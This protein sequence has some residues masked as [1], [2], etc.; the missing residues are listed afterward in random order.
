MNL[1]VFNMSNLQ[2]WEQGIVNRNYFVVRELLRRNEFDQIFLVDFLAVQ[3]KKKP[4]GMRRSFR[5]AKRL[6]GGHTQRRGLF[7]TMTQR[8]GQPFGEQT[9]RFHVYQ[10]LGMLTDHKRDLQAISEWLLSHG[11][12]AANLVIWSYN[13]FLPEALTMPARLRVFDAVDN[14][15]LHASYQNDASLLRR[16]YQLISGRADVIF[17]VSEG[18]Q[19]LFPKEKA[20]WIPNGVDLSPFTKAQQVPADIS[21]LPKPVVGYVGTVQERL[22]F[23]LMEFVCKRHSD[24]SFVFIGPVWKGVKEQQV[25]LQTKCPNVHFLGRRPYA[26]VPAY[27]Q[28]MD[29][30]II[31][32]RLDAFISSTNPMKMYD[33]LAAGKPVVTTPGAGTELFET[34]MHV[35]NTSQE[36]AQAIDAAIKEQTPE[37]IAQRRKAVQPHGWEARVNAMVDAVQTMVM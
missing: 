30:A 17:T 23:E 3:S 24:K 16:N 31:P 6:L 26:S 8:E 25:R 27:L 22:D 37:Q 28:A 7:H 5:Y 13:A 2:D 33:Y 4:F 20:R 12:D 21:M 18:L 19:A 15:S 35:V 1:L 9:K 36:F 10:G 32:H 29:V 14:W 11:V 34:H